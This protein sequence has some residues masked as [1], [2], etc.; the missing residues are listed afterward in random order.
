MLLL[1]VLFLMATAAGSM[2]LPET[3]K[4][5]AFPASISGRIFLKNSSGVIVFFSSTAVPPLIILNYSKIQKNV[6]AFGVEGRAGRRPF[7]SIK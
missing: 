2:L 1:T 6:N 7:L 5:T 4:S 3:V